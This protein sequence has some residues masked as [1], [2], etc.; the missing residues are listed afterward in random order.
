MTKK[1]TSQTEPKLFKMNLPIKGKI[2]YLS[3]YNLC[4]K[5]DKE[6]KYR[7]SPTV[8]VCR[9]DFGKGK[10]GRKIL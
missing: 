2:K 4:Q 7:S 6:N 10:K 8:E 9:K 1:K 5:Y 3:E